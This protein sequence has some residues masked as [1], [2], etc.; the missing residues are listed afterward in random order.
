MSISKLVAVL[1]TV[2]VI[3]S[4][5]VLLAADPDIS[6]SPDTYDFGYGIV[7]VCLPSNFTLANDGDATL[8]VLDVISSDPAVFHVA[9]STPATVASNATMNVIISFCP[10]A[11]ADYTGT[12][13]FV[14]ND[15]DESNFVVNLSGTA[16]PPD[17]SV[18]PDTFDFGYGI[19]GACLP[20]N[21]IIANNGHGDLVVTDVTSSDPAIFEVTVST[22][23]TIGSGAT[24]GIVIA[25]CPAAELDY[26]GTVTFVSNDPGGDFVVNLSGT[27]VPPD[28]SVTPD[29]YNFGYGIIGACLPGDFILANN[30]HGDLVVSDVISSDPAIFEVA[31]STPLTIGSGATVGMVISFCP[32][33]PID[34]EGT[35]T[36]VSNDPDGDFVVH[37]SGTSVE[38]D[39]S[40]EP[41]DAINGHDFGA[42]RL[43]N[44]AQWTFVMKNS[45]SAT[46]QFDFDFATDLPFS[47][48]PT[49]GTLGIGSETT[50]TVT[51]HSTDLGAVAETLVLS[52]PNP[53]FGGNIEFD[54]FGFGVAPDIDAITEYQFPDTP[55]HAC[56]DYSLD[57]TNIATD[58]TAVLLNVTNVTSDAAD[59]TIVGVTNATI[60]TGASK[61]FTIR[62]CPSTV[63]TISG[64]ITVYSDDPDSP[65]WEIDVL[66]VG[67]EAPYMQ[68]PNLAAVADF[69]TLRVGE[70][71]TGTLEIANMGDANLEITNIA[72]TEN[73]Q[74]FSL[75]FATLGTLAAGIATQWTIE[76]GNSLFVD[77]SFHPTEIGATT[78][79]LTI[80]SNDPV[81]PTYETTL[82]G[83]AQAAPNV[84]VN[85]TSLDFG[86]LFV[87]D[88]AQ[89]TFTISNTSELVP[90]N[91]ISVTCVGADYAVTVGASLP[92]T[93]STV[94]PVEVVV[95]FTPS[96]MGTIT[97]TVTVTTDDPET[98]SVQVSLTGVGFED[99]IPPGAITD[100]AAQ[101][102]A[103]TTAA[104]LLSWTAPADD[105][106][107]AT[108]GPCV[109]YD[110]RYSDT[111]PINTLADFD[112]ATPLDASD[113][114]PATPGTLEFYEFS[115]PEES[116]EYWFA[117]TST[118]DR[119]NVSLLSNTANAVS[120][121][122][123]LS[124][125][126]ASAGDGRVVLTWQT[127]SE[128]ENLGFY[129]MR[130][131]DRNG[132]FSRLNRRLIAGAGTTVE[133]RFYS[134]TDESVSNGQ[135]YYYYLAAV[136]YS[137]VEQRSELVAASPVEG[138]WAVSVDVSTNKSRF[139]PGD[140]L[141]LTVGAANRGETVLVDA[142]IWVTLPSGRNLD[143]LSVDSAF[144]DGGVVVVADL[145][146]Y[147]FTK[148]DAVGQYLITCMITDSENGSIMSYAVTSLV[149]TS[150]ASVTPPAVW[151]NLKPSSSPATVLDMSRDDMFIT[152]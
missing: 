13:T 81:E 145:L 39:V 111:G 41:A 80:L 125:F 136:E 66:G 120:L 18:T 6:V 78:G 65:A 75:D 115:M 12:V 67:L 126:K 23:L 63:G 151:R 49:T 8:S 7:G 83:I 69:G 133:P 71:T 22:P 89:L 72:I 103:A 19:V 25:F 79:V 2:A 10:A 86:T 56:S 135:T 40:F 128:M 73:V 48:L 42:V 113:I 29:T 93:I 139:L 143:L 87:D 149:L 47:V 88:T 105:A 99:L 52:S 124:W 140:E 118:D 127:A 104:I 84:V 45:T 46:T 50:I 138:R 5:Q 55:K 137:G 82:M 53:D 68:F 132:R 32:A 102:G 112:A 77:I 131:T 33:E 58:A 121:A 130:S 109:S 114:I 4:A 152:K 14:S 110:I 122:V 70:V 57:V 54:L 101:T 148:R 144:I 37:V 119:D 142:R 129:L 60:A 34:Y 51:F 95:E 11:E 1:A 90:L 147:A 35:V 76:P 123:E 44:A 38:S 141:V 74:S 150:R 26:E 100:L 92:V 146:N 85:P 62:F 116:V 134:Y 30:G 96:T 3:M 16:V 36:F 64:V 20:G 61:S 43:P 28:I 107:D 24:V 97:G 9:F 31:L 106:T 15:P 117:M 17:I 21:F 108:S 91:L 27:A 98:P 59:F 94:S